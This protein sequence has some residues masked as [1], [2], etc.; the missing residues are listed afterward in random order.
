MKSCVRSPR[1][2]LCQQQGRN[3]E[4]MALAGEFQVLA[5]TY[6]SNLNKHSFSAAEADFECP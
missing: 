2:L 4:K 1:S 6:T 5:T 3:E